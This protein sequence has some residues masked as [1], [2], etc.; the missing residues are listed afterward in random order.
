MKKNWLAVVASAGVA[1]VIFAVAYFE[2]LAPRRRM[3]RHRLTPHALHRAHRHPRRFRR[4]E[5]A[6]PYRRRTF[7]PHFPRAVV[8][9]RART[10]GGERCALRSLILLGLIYIAVAFVQSLYAAISERFEK[11]G[12]V[13]A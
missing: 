6:L 4:R 9:H 13:H 11:S 5:I 10:D 2:R 1:A 8:L 7:T 3:D 12:K